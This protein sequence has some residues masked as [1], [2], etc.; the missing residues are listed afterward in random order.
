MN[1]VTWPPRNA[2]VVLHPPTQRLKE[3]FSCFQGEAA[4]RGEPAGGAERGPGPLHRR[5]GG[6]AA[7]PLP[8]VAPAGPELAKGHEVNI[9]QGSSPTNH[10]TSQDAVLCFCSTLRPAFPSVPRPAGQSLTQPYLHFREPLNNVHFRTVP[11]CG[12]EGYL[13][14]NLISQSS[15][16]CLIHPPLAY[17]QTRLANM[18]YLLTLW[19]REWTISKTVKLKHVLNWRCV[20]KPES[21]FLFLLLYF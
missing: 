5:H 14:I 3:L 17:W 6:S 18:H 19:Q 9:D 8:H 20:I 21:D 15:S 7:E 11:L 2:G 4:S 13:F 16:C 10:P 1:V 12:S